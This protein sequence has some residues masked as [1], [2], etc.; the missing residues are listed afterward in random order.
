[1]SH[2]IDP[3]AAILDK[4]GDIDGIELFNNQVLVAIYIRPEKTKA[5]IILPDQTRDEDQHQS[6]VG[7]VLKMGDR[8]FDDHYREKYTDVKIRKDD[9]IFFRASDGWATTINKVLCRI[10][11]D[12]DVKGRISGP[13]VVW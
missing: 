3:V 1:M 9:W 5:G 12:V 11:E 7:L 6:K 8:A 2:E 4:I 10:V 13:D